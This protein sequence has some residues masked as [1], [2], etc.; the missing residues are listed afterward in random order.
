MQAQLKLRKTPWT[1]SPLLPGLTFVVGLLIG[2]GGVWLWTHRAVQQT[3]TALATATYHLNIA[4][5][6]LDKLQKI[7]DLRK[8]LEANFTK[9]LDPNRRSDEANNG[10]DGKNKK[11]SAVQRIAKNN[12]SSLSESVVQLEE[13][14]AKLENREP[15][16]F[17]FLPKTSHQLQIL[18][19][20]R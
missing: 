20:P 5:Y 4:K 18:R 2:V 1:A 16:K 9:I 8:E 19:L 14:L 11:N 10:E 15:R 6:E 12:I 17:D 13:A 3:R 7:T